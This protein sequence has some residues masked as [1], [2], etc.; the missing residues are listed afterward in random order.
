MVSKICICFFVLIAG[1]FANEH[2]LLRA[3]KIEIPA[4]NG[5]V[6]TATYYPVTATNNNSVILIH[7]LGR[8]RGDWNELAR[9]LQRDGI[10]VLSFDLR[11]HGES[12]AADGRPW[13]LFNDNEFQA[14]G[15]DIDTVYQYAMRQLRFQPQR[16][17]LVGM[18]LGANLALQ[19]AEKNQRLAGVALISPG[20]EYRS[21]KLQ[22]KSYQRALY[23]IYSKFEKD[24]IEAGEYLKETFPGKF[25]LDV[26][27]HSGTLISLFRQRFSLPDSISR[28]F[29]QV[30]AD[31]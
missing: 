23:V 20:M 29:K 31:T 18:G 14:F 9:Y 4:A 13:R 3:Q 22:N 28:W 19:L 15:N 11:G 8:N 27:E 6:I 21:V 2:R 10:A 24:S 7:A 12:I 1:L 30:F 16:T 26:Y 25:K 17:G 5:L